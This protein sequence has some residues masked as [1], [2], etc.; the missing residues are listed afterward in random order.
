MKTQLKVTL[1]LLLMVL[2]MSAKAGKPEREVSIS[3]ENNKAVVLYMKNLVGKTGIALIDSDGNTV[4]SDQTSKDFYGK[5][6]NLESIKEGD[7]ILE[8][9]NAEKLEVMTVAVTTNSASIKEKEV[10][11]VKPLVRMSDETAKVFFAGT[12]EEVEISLYNSNG[13]IQYKGEHL[14]KEISSKK[15]DLSDLEEGTYRFKFRINNRNFYH[16]I[17]LN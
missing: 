15:F 9:D 4:F 6:L 2:G 11:V 3:V 8:I 13:V 1:V 12:G 10:L 5:I 7:Y 16:T 17:V 14:D